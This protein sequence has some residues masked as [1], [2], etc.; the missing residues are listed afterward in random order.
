M[1]KTSSEIIVIGQ[2]ISYY[3]VLEK[4]GEWGAEHT[5]EFFERPIARC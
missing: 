2:T 4:L 3:R 5:K 1:V